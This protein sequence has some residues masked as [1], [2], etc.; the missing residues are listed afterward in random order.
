MT[1]LR[2]RGCELVELD[3]TSDASVRSAESVLKRVDILVNNAGCASDIICASEACNATF[4]PA[5]PPPPSHRQG[6]AGPM[7]ELSIDEMKAL[8]ETNVFGLIRMTQVR[9]R[10]CSD[11]RQTL[12]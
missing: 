11:G 8:Y 3:V 4:T 2:E 9:C 12:G 10:N 1:G 6:L 7:A 5:D